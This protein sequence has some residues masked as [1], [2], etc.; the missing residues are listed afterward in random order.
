M[1]T[2]KDVAQ[3]ARFQA[4][5]PGAAVQH[6]Q[7][8]QDDQAAFDTAVAWA[9]AARHYRSKKATLPTDA[10]YARGRQEQQARLAERSVRAIAMQSEI[11]LKRRHDDALADRAMLGI[12]LGAAS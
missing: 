3:Q 4:M 5:Q 2:L 6:L 7:Q 10:G 1:Q 8:V 9:K 11:R 12:M